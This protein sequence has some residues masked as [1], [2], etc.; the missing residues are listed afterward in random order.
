MCLRHRRVFPNTLHSL[1]RVWAG[2]SYMLET[3][4]PEWKWVLFYYVIEQSFVK[5]KYLSLKER[6]RY[7]NL[8]E[9]AL[10]RTMWRA[11]FGRGFGPVVR[12][13]IKWMNE[14]AKLDT[15]YS[16]K[17]RIHILL[18]VFFWVIPRRL[19]F[20]CW[21]FGTLCLFHFHRQVGE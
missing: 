13:T 5:I 20:I 14:V 1:S 4:L 17:M 7:S 21:R 12:Q 18:Y 11:H 10:D 8:N 6:R 15:L 16:V 3:V 19:N 2:D 9:E